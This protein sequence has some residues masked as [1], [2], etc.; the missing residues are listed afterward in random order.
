MVIWLSLQVAIFNLG[1][2]PRYDLAV[3]V[4]SAF[5]VLVGQGHPE[6]PE[7]GVDR[8]AGGSY[9][10]LGL[11]VP[12]SGWGHP[13]VLRPSLGILV[14]GCWITLEISWWDLPDLIGDVEN[15]I[16][17][18]NPAILRNLIEVGLITTYVTLGNSALLIWDVHLNKFLF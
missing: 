18:W 15:G 5:L 17:V 12:R 14:D 3:L 13:D 10:G 7:N 11:E 8:V 6:M 16:A 1:L 4:Q 9:L 2:P